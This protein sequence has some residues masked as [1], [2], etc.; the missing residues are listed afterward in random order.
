MAVDEAR[1]T[2]AVQDAGQRQE[3][4]APARG[5]LAAPH[6]VQRVALAAPMLTH[7]SSRP[8]TASRC[9]P[10]GAARMPAA[11]QPGVPTGVQPGMGQLRVP[12]H[13]QQTASRWG[14]FQACERNAPGPGL[15]PVQGLPSAAQ[16]AWLA[17]HDGGE[18]VRGRAG[19]EQDCPGRLAGGLD[20]V[21]TGRRAGAGA[22][23]HALGD[24]AVTTAVD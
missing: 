3:Q 13:R 8:V 1:C 9:Q 19:S 4:P 14:A 24:A 16:R 17:G 23:A 22:S 21:Q 5:L 11:S 18:G 2:Q 10:H 12:E 6:S 20:A 7:G 15:A